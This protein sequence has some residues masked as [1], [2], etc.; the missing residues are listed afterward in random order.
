M[1]SIVE[2]AYYSIGKWP[3]VVLEG[4]HL[5]HLRYKGAYHWG[6]SF[7]DKI[8]TFDEGTVFVPASLKKKQKYILV[9]HGTNHVRKGTNWNGT[10]LF[11]YIKV[12]F[13]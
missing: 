13:H 5:T 2:C 7:K 9:A 6:G 3:L 12:K 11:L 10:N 4:T 8:C 1:G